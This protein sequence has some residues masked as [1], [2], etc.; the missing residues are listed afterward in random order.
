MVVIA[1]PLCSCRGAASALTRC[2]RDNE[3]GKIGCRWKQACVYQWFGS[4]ISHAIRSL[5]LK[6]RTK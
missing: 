6:V 5:D 1:V 3:E 2:L 4:A